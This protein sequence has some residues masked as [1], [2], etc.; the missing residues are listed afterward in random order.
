IM[1]KSIA[2]IASDA[3]PSLPGKCGSFDSQM[4]AGEVS[5][6]SFKSQFCDTVSLGVAWR[7]ARGDVRVCVAFRGCG[8]LHGGSP[9]MTKDEFRRRMDQII[10]AHDA[11]MAALPRPDDAIAESA[12]QFA[13]VQ[14]AMRRYNEARAR[15]AAW[16]SARIDVSLAA[17]QA[18]RDLMREW[19]S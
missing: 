1:V 9:A 3:D 13:A 16:Q 10:E 7:W 11:G 8:R 14:E 5:I 15:V 6:L 19:E 2:D 4:F 17:N 12:A 18:V